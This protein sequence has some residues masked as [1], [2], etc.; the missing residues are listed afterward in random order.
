MIGNQSSPTR[1]STGL[2]DIGTMPQRERERDREREI[3]AA[4][5]EMNDTTTQLN[6]LVSN[7]L[8]RLAPIMSNRPEPQTASATEAPLHERKYY[9][10]LAGSIADSTST[11]RYLA[12][13]LERAIASLEL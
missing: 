7:L 4:L 3:P 10:G 2:G 12:T 11:L 6:N 9:S 13:E 5:R 1:S 8:D